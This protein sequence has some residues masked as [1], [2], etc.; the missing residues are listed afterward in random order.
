[1]N[2]LN[3]EEIDIVI[4]SLIISGRAVAFTL[5]F[6]IIFGWILA[7]RKFHGKIL[8]DALLHTSLIL[9]PVVVGF[10]LLLIFGNNGIIG[11]ILD[12]FGI[13]L[14][15]TSAGAS[16]AAG[17]M[18][19]PLM[20]RACRQ[21]IENV[22]P[23]IEAMAQSL[24][25]GFW[26]VMFSIILPCA[27]NGII[28][29]IIIGFAASLGEFGAVITFASN[30]KGETQTLALAIYSALQTPNGDQTALKL[31]IISILIAI[32]ALVCAETLMNSNRKKADDT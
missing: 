28:A 2:F 24:G 17:T 10:L 21:A 27:R 12:K 14:V 32:L 3:A 5:P 29:A 31:S 7:K 20:L 9:P 16:F 19:F 13:Q 23:K 4:L 11:K 30:I 8:L 25:A 18:A 22:D 6:A 1:M 26:D 15:F